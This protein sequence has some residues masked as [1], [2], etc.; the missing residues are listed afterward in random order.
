MT[1]TYTHLKRYTRPKDFMDWADFDRR[2]YFVAI[3][4]HRDSDALTRSNFRVMLATLGG[5]SETVQVLRDSH[6]A[7]G[8]VEVIYVHESNADACQI[9]DEQLAHLEDY[10]ALDEQDL[11][12]LEQEEADLTW[13]KCYTEK[14]RIAYIREHRQQFE[15]HD[16]ADLR[17]CVRGKYY[18][19]YASELLG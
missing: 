10:P 16:W 7:V 1:D 4:R 12:K 11:S 18:S 8:W 13:R 14:D 15:F 6:W 3:G 9:A 5:E 17:A 2:E 19:G